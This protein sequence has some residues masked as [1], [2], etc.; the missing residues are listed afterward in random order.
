MSTL[1]FIPRCILLSLC[2]LGSVVA[3]AQEF[4]FWPAYQLGQ[5]AANYPGPKTEMPVTHTAIVDAQHTPLIFFGEDPTQRIYNFSDASKLPHGSFS[6]EMWMVNHVNRPVGV[7]TTLKGKQGNTEPDWLVGIF[8]N[9]LV[10]SLQTEDSH[11]A[12]VIQTKLDK[13]GWKN[14]WRHVVATYNGSDMR[15]YVNGE[16]VAQGS[17]GKRKVLPSGYELEVA[18][19]SQHEPYMTIGNLLKMLRIHPKALSQKEIEASKNELQQMVTEGKLFPDLFHFTAGPYLNNATQN[20]ISLV[21]ET[22]RAADFAIEYGERV[23]YDKKI[24]VNTQHLRREGARAESNIHKITLTD[25][26]PE[27]PYYYNIKA[28]SR[29]GKMIDSGPLTFTTAVRDSSSF[30]FAVMG[31]TEAR[32]HINDRVAKQIWDERPNFVM[33]VGDLTDGGMK[34]HKFE[35]NYEYFQGITQLASRV[36][37][38]PVPGNG[39]GDL[40]WYNQYHSL[41]RNDGFYSFR[42][43]NAEFFMLNSNRADEFAPGG[44]QYVWLEKQLQQSTA[45]WKFVAHHHAPYSA[46]DDDYGDTWKGPAE[47]GDI[48]IRKIVPLYEKYNVD[49]VFFGYLHT[50]QRT[51]PI[52]NGKVTRSNGVIYVQGGGGGG[53]LEDF[54]PSRA[55]FSAKTYRGHHYFTITI[56]DTVLNFKMYDTEGRLK[57]YLDLS[58]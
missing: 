43:G 32:P 55:W 46:D 44:K 30:S 15:L 7:L 41:P 16:L 1:N 48:A 22:D 9:E 13:R 54:A 23:P 28:V 34:D 17:V 21:W 11:F 2:C 39:E 51:L 35:W 58:K 6:I 50:Y 45:A 40:Y 29:D 20:S 8:A 42:Y 49:M 37:V 56:N 4:W 47:S 24:E 38:F 19:Y 25:L 26:R 53:N 57:D 14:Y 5:K 52:R 10:Y 33:I 27:T 3:N 18:S 36:P 31:D 12:N